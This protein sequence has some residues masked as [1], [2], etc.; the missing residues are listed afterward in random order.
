MSEYITN[1]AKPICFY[2]CFLS[3]VVS[4]ISLCSCFFTLYEI[5][6]REIYIYRNCIEQLRDYAAVMQTSD[7]DLF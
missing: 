6:G 4:A 7:W 5:I 1:E 3:I 2:G